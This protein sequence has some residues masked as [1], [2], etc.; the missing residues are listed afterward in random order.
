MGFRHY[1]ASTKDNLMTPRTT[2]L[3]MNIIDRYILKSHIGPFFLSFITIIFVLVLQFLAGFSDRFLGKGIGFA[4][5]AEL[6]M[7]QSA[8]MVVFAVPMAVLISVIM[9]YGAMTNASEMTVLR[10]SGLSLF[11]L[12]TPVLLV[13]LGLSLLVERFNNVVIPDA[14]YRSKALMAD[15]LR[16]RPA[17]GLTENAFSSFIDGYSIYVRQ[18][19]E[20][21][22]EM[23]GVRLYDLTRPGH[24]TMVSAEKGIIGF[25]PDDRYLVMTLFNGELHEIGY[26]DPARYR[27]MSFSRH[28]I[29]FE[30]SGFGF[31]RTAEDRMR[32][33]A[34]ELS[35]GELLAAG[36]VLKREVAAAERISAGGGA[37][38]QARRRLVSLQEKYNG[39]MAEFHKKYALPV[40]CL[41]FALAGVPLGVLARRGGFGAG[42]GLSLLFFVLYWSMIIS[43][44]KLAERGIL[45]PAPAIWSADAILALAALLLIRRLNGSV[46]AGSR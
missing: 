17:F 37:G 7:L 32:G 24:R 23:K 5:I 16:A 28:R 26:P 20:A 13:A 6:V 2:I 4:D 8:W 1:I 42:A 33:D 46:A 36:K 40:A 19:D 45:D 38:P 41:V 22:G 34:R 3:S 18:T 25:S 44:E 21:S 31:S 10:S 27:T 14:N 9:V 12:A 43:G 15:I 30:S 39:Y 35:A 29:V 11:R